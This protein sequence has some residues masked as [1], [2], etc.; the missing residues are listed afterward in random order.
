MLRYR[1]DDELPLDAKAAADRPLLLDTTVYIDRSQ[2]K[3]PRAIMGRIVAAQHRIFH[4]GVVCAELAISLGL[5]SPDHPRT[6]AT[7]AAIL[8]HLDHMVSHRAI[9]PSATAWTE[10]AVVPAS[11]RARRGWQPKTAARR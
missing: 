11:W 3:L 9:S 5:L 8:A 6:P 2:S 1:P 7:S 10:A 4:C